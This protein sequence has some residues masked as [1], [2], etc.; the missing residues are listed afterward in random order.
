VT[1]FSPPGDVRQGD[2]VA[3]DFFPSWN[4]ENLSTVIGPAG[5][6][7]QLIPA[8]E[9]VQRT[10]D[11]QFIVA[12][13]AYDCDLENPRSRTGVALAPVMKVPA[14]PRDPTYD[15]ILN[16]AKRGENN[17]L[18]Y[19]Q[20]FPVELEERLG[21]RFE[22]GVVDFS[23]LMH[24]APAARVVEILAP[25]VIQRLSDDLREAFRFKLAAFFGRGEP[26]D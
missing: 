4:V 20:L 18:D 15:A 3:L 1:S 2:L 7:S 19:F 16:S 21:A 9:K 10:G 14:S 25:R 22:V 23:Q 24:M 11:G 6:Q 12:V 13:C 17:R 5:S 8:A 26:V